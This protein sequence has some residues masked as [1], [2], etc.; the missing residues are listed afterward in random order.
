MRLFICR[1]RKASTFYR[2]QVPFPLPLSLGL[3]LMLPK[4]KIYKISN[5]RI[6]IVRSL[7]GAKK[8][9]TSQTLR[10]IPQT[11]IFLARS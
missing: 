11:R 1:L 10:Y 7:Q 2:G 3:Y 9:A 4:H 5:A 6:C 8:D